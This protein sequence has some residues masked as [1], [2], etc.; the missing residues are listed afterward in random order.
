MKPITKDNIYKALGLLIH[1]TVRYD[2]PDGTW[3]LMPTVYYGIGEDKA[4]EM[5]EKWKCGPG[6]GLLERGVPETMW[7]LRITDACAV[8]DLGYRETPKSV[9]WKHYA[10][11]L[12]WINL[13]LI[14]IQALSVGKWKD[15]LLLL[16]RLCRVAKY[17]W[18]VFRMGASSYFSE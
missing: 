18:A 14:V 13:A 7:G 10:D 1:N 4:E 6:S 8:H 2:L 9:E 5:W 11:L 15:K 3:I 12:F 17:F 16:P